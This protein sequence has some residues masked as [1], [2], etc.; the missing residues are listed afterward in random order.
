M[1]HTEYKTFKYNELPKHIQTFVENYMQDKFVNNSFLA[2]HI[3]QEVGDNIISL[4]GEDLTIKNSNVYLVQQWFINQGC[5]N[6][7]ILVLNTNI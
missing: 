3:G 5:L 1:K 6:E 2:I 7:N 4:Y